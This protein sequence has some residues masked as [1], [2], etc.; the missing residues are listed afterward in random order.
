MAGGRFG[1]ARVQT[2]M[3]SPLPGVEYSGRLGVF[4][5]ANGL[6][7][8]L[9]IVGDYL[10]VATDV[11]TADGVHVAAELATLRAGRGGMAPP[12]DYMLEDGTPLDAPPYALRIALAGSGSSDRLLSVR[13]GRRAP[14][15]LA[16]LRGYPDQAR[17]LVCAAPIGVDDAFRAQERERVVLPVMPEYFGTGWSGEQHGATLGMFRRMTSNAAVLVPSATRG[18][19]HI[20]LYAHH[21]AAA[22]SDA[23]VSLRLNDVADLGAHALVPGAPNRADKYEWDVPERAW[24]EGTNELLLTVKGVPAL[25]LTRLSIAKR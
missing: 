6:G 2:A 7:E 24:L 14:R 11:E 13:L 19:V 3:W 17:A 20:T 12:P 8:L 1:C 22:T 21:T 9:L 16:R 18:P 25:D 4:L 23:T 10:P 5:P 15:V